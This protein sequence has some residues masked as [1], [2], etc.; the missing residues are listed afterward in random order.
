M[1][2]KKPTLISIVSAL[3][4]IAML[5]LVPL[6]DY[7]P[8]SIFSLL[9]YYWRFGG[10][11]LV[12]FFISVPLFML[13]R[14][15]RSFYRG[16]TGRGILSLSI[17]AAG[18]IALPAGRLLGDGIAVMAVGSRLEQA[19][20]VGSE[21]SASIE[22]GPAAAFYITDDFFIR[23][24]IAFDTTGRLGELLALEP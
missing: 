13:W 10:L 7:F 5:S 16:Q 18:M 20:R 1:Q 8:T 24:G 2:V 23:Q 9:A 17:I 12:I 22:V 19:V 21:N 6:I 11:P 3:W 14:A 4:L 15:A